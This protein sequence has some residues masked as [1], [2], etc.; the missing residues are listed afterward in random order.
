MFFHRQVLQFTSVESPVS[1][2]TCARNQER[3][4]RRP[5][6]FFVP[7][8]PTLRARGLFG[9]LRLAP[10]ADFF[11]VAFVLATGSATR[12]PLRRARRR[13]RF[14][15]LR[16]AEACLRAAFA[17]RFASLTRLRARFSS[18]LASRTRCLATSAC[19]R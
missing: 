6:R 4:L 16:A 17:S 1:R 3:R 11:R 18:S 14:H 9:C 5:L 19:K 7:F 8:L 13:A 15:S 12:A 10:E 2:S